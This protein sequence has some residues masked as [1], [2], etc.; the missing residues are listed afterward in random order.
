MSPAKIWQERVPLG[1]DAGATGAGG[2]RDIGGGQAE[3]LMVDG[4][5]MATA[6]RKMKRAARRPPFGFA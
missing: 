3:N 2:L 6:S 4:G 1:M 5:I